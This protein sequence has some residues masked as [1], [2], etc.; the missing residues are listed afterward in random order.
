MR[1][2]RDFDRLANAVDEADM[3]GKLMYRGEQD[4]KSRRMGINVVRLNRN[5]EGEESLVVKEEIFGPI[6]PII[7]V[8]VGRMARYQLLTCSGCRHGHPL[9]QCA[10][11]AACALRVLGEPYHV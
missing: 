3:K 5:A 9:R 2:S 7:P 6:L 10:P 11:H 4:P 1:N 8:D